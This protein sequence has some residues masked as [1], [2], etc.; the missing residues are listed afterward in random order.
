MT[1]AAQWLSDKDERIALRN[2]AAV[3]V[4][5]TPVKSDLFNDARSWQRYPDGASDWVLDASTRSTINVPELPAPTFMM[6][7]VLL[8][9]FL[10]L[11][12]KR[13]LAG[14]RPLPRIT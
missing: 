6:A 2:L 10:L 12:W 5:A 9:T 4:D 14:S 8:S 1:Q 3:E 11:R 13:L 7:L